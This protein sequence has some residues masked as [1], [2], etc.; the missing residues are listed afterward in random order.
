MPRATSTGLYDRYLL[1]MVFVVLLLAVRYYQD[2]VQPRL[3]YACLALSFS[4]RRPFRSRARTILFAMFRGVLAAADEVH[5]SGVP[6]RAIDAGW[7]YDGLTEII[8]RRASS[9]LPVEV[10]LERST[11]GHHL[12]RGLARAH[13][14]SRQSSRMCCRG[15]ACPL[16][17]MPAGEVRFC[18]CDLLDAVAAF[19]EW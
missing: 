15:I 9:V 3:P 19:I 6:E 13:R 5:A 11:F 10:W 17:P 18:A 16:I 14:N 1:P 8:M 7:E 2:N 12:R 4:C